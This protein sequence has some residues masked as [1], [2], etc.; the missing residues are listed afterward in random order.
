MLYK[1]CALNLNK[2]GFKS[3]SIVGCGFEIHWMS[4]ACRREANFERKGEGGE[5]IVRVR[6]DSMPK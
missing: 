6:H 3:W 2:I 5:G 4:L 1:K